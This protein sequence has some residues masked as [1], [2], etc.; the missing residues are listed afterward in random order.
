MCGCVC[1][2]SSFIYPPHQLI[3]QYPE[4][5]DRTKSHKTYHFRLQI[6]VVNSM[7]AE[8]ITQSCKKVVAEERKARSVGQ[9]DHPEVGMYG[10][11]APWGNLGRRRGYTREGIHLTERKYF[12][13]KIWSNIYRIKFATCLLYSGNPLNKYKLIWNGHMAQTSQPAGY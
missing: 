12:L 2:P 6:R 4:I 8:D 1:P 7:A 5:T 9:H 13:K 3:S 11:Y 10:D